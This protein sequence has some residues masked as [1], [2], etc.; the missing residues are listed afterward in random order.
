M[1]R[2]DILHMTSFEAILLRRWQILIKIFSGEI[3][4]QKNN[5]TAQSPPSQ[6]RVWHEI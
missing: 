3:K 2:K 5:S 4:Y 6:G 1:K